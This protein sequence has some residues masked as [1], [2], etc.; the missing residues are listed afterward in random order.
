M[1]ADGAHVER[2][3]AARRHVSV[4]RGNDAVRA[5][6]P[7]ARRHAAIGLDDLLRATEGGD[8]IRSCR[9]A[10]ILRAIKT[11]GAA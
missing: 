8:G 7:C 4:V 10:N 5:L 3:G 6:A 11:W 1:F 9:C 2:A